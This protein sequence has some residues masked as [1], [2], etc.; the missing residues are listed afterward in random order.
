MWRMKQ[1]VTLTITALLT[2]LLSSFHLA[3][4]VVLGIDRGDT[5]SYT[6][7]L[8]L[9]VYLYGTL[10]LSGRRWAHLIVL[11]GSIGGAFVPYL[12]MTGVG[13]VGG[14]AANA[15]G[16]LFWV[17]TLLALGVTGIISAVLS[18]RELW[19]LRRRRAE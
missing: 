14:K 16:K 18:V 11:I 10:M 2:I 7:V 6:G 13:M 9:V 17:W 4:D 19:N 5:S 3:H 1:S 8:I 15:S 12:H